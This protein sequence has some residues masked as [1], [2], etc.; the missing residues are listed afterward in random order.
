MPY[1]LSPEQK[2]VA[3]ALVSKETSSTKYFDIITALQSICKGCS[4]AMVEGKKVLIHI[5]DQNIKTAL[6]K[7]LSLNGLEDITIDISTETYI[8]ELDIIKL[9]STLKKEKNITPLIDFVLSTKKLQ[10]Q[11]KVL[12][13]FYVALDKPVLTDTPFRDFATNIIYNKDNNR[14]KI[15]TQETSAEEMNFTTSEYYKVKKEINKSSVIYQK[16]YELFDHLSLFKNNLW[17]EINEGRV[18]EIKNQLELFRT[19]SNILSG[20]FVKVSNLLFKSCSYDLKNSFAELND[21]F[22]FHL[23]ASIAYN[24]KESSDS[25][26]KEGGFSLFKKKKKQAS[27]KIYIEAFDNLSTSIQEISPEWYEEL[28]APTAEMI[29][30]DYIVNFIEAN[31][32]KSQVFESE[33]T[34]KLEQSV[35]RINK[36]NSSSEDVSLLDKRLEELIREMNNS[37]LFDLE[38]DHNILS[39]LKQSELSQNISDY[40]EKCYI[41]FHSSSTYL[42]W[43]SFYNA[44][45]SIFKWIF[46][47]I[48]ILPVSSWNDTFENWYEHKLIDHVLGNFESDLE[49]NSYYKQAKISNQTEIQA[50]IAQ[51]HSTR[52]DG[53]QKL[54]IE[55]KEL[56]NTLFKKKQLPNVSWKNTVLM[57]KSFMQS[58]FPIHLSDTTAHALEYDLVISFEKQSED[59][60]SNIHYFAPI[61]SEDIQN[62]AQNKNNFLYLNDYNYNGLLNNLS[63]TDKL[64]ASKKL[65]KFILSLNQNIKIYQLKNANVISLVPAYDDAKLEKELDGLNAKVI[66]THGVLYDRLTESILFTERKPFL[67]IKDK[68]INSELYEHMLWQLKILEIFKEAGYE[69]YSINTTEQLQDNQLIFD[70]L[71]NKIDGE[72]LNSKEVSAPSISEKL[73]TK[74]EEV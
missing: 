59:S 57:N 66:D 6:S 7:L 49:L 17:E 38:L 54:K 27:N 14:P 36:I 69:I 18:Q 61:S 74:Q 55:S 23:E 44:S 42:E 19:E 15:T 34:K 40:L 51:L 72:Y 39:F 62:L 4:T 64:K 65:A 50:L 47:K 63:S 24:I 25:E 20:D 60:P 8:P 1:I 43:K 46:N 29:T 45:S 67:V 11:N 37:E 3:D 26:K 2:V 71:I 68:L 5:P 13:D 16:Q 33:I 48:K 10:K 58:V 28:D 12:S 21:Q 73:E 22:T 70:N 56:Y 35:Q 52:I 41:L 30:Y 31:Q 32:K 9:R 53:I